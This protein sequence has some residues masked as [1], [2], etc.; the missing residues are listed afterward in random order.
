MRDQLS[1]SL[2]RDVD[3]AGVP[4][5]AQ[6]V[7]ELIG[8]LRKRG[9]PSVAH[10]LERALSTRTVRVEFNA[11]EREVIARAV[12][13]RPERFSEL[14][15]VLI[16]EIKRRRAR[17]RYVIALAAAARSRYRVLACVGPTRSTQ[18]AQRQAS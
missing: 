17:S 10:K 3:V 9:Y 7:P 2:R 8:R 18:S 6:H 5:Q 14:Y 13:D 15:E 12:A 16:G 1:M 4:V 11:T